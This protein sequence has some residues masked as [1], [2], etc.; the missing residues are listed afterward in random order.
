MTRPGETV[1]RI[2]VPLGDP[3]AL[4]AAPAR[5]GVAAQLHD[6]SGQVGASPSLLSS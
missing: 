3:D 6:A 2:T 5:S 1:E 4:L